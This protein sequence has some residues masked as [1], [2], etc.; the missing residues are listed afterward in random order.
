MAVGS[1]V[2][3][4]VVSGSAEG[5]A[6]CVAVTSGTDPRVGVG[7]LTTAPVCW[8]GWVATEEAEFER[9]GLAGGA[10]ALLLAGAWVAL[11]GDG[12]TCVGVGRGVTLAG[13]VLELAVWAGPV[14]PV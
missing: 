6:E 5:C 14:C 8:L 3:G 1:G 7:L 2:C 10:E 11:T 9:A 13:G 4:G 12:G